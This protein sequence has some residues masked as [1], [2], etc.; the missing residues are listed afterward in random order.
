MP[1]EPLG[2]VSAQRRELCHGRC[3]KVRA[4]WE[5]QPWCSCECCRSGYVL[6]SPGLSALCLQTSGVQ[7]LT[8]FQMSPCSLSPRVLSLLLPHPGIC[9]SPGDLSVLGPCPPHGAEG[10]SVPGPELKGVRARFRALVAG[11]P[12]PNLCCHHP[13]EHLHWSCKH[14]H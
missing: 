11:C 12:C 9:P 6:G 5:T 13:T 10:G 1:R 2:A 4:L 3:D 7:P 8:A 14:V